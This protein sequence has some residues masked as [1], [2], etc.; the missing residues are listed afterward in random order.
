QPVGSWTCAPLGQSNRPD[1]PHHSD[2]AEKLFSRRKMKPSWW[3]PRELARHIESRSVIE[4][5][6]R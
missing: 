1:S 6:L 3:T 2:Q 5:G 4:T